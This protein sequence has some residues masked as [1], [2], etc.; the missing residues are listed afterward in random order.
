MMIVSPPISIVWPRP[1]YHSIDILN[2]NVLV[3][4]ETKRHLGVVTIDSVEQ[5][6][7]MMEQMSKE[8]ELLH[9]LWDAVQGYNFWVAKVVARYGSPPEWLDE[10][11]ELLQRQQVVRDKFPSLFDWQKRAKKLQEG[12]W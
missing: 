7:A 10:R 12:E 3:D 5:L 11:R 8:L 4:D 2:P 1:D 9:E 6:Y